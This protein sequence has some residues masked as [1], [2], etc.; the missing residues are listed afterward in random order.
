MN[1]KEDNECIEHSELYCYCTNYVNNTYVI[2]V[3]SP[4]ISELH[5]EKFE[6]VEGE[7]EIEHIWKFVKAV[8]KLCNATSHQASN[9]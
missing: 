7:F 6:Y 4:E 5:K 8:E 2:K 3:S 9:S 1:C